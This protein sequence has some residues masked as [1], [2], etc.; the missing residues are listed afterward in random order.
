MPRDSRASTF[1]CAC[2]R[3]APQLDPSPLLRL[4][5]PA[6]FGGTSD[7]AVVSAAQQAPDQQAWIPRPHGHALG[8]GGSVPPPQEGPQAAHRLAAV[9]AR[10]F[11]TPSARLPRAHRL[12][13]ASDIRRCLTHGRRR[14]FEHLDMIWMDNTTGQPRMGLIVPKFQSSAVARNR[15]RRRLREIWRLEIQ[16][17]QPA[18]D[19]VIKARREAYAAAFDALRAQLLALARRRAGCR[20]TPC[21]SSARAAPSAARHAHPRLPALHLAARCRRAAGFTHPAPS[22]HSKRSPGTAPSGAPGWPRVGS[23]A[24]IR[25]IRAGS[26]PSPDLVI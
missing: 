8:T 23:S 17:A 24:V 14:R 9:E 2:S 19:L 10:G 11:L 15:F 1:A 20:V 7:E 18:W 16:R 22:T 21:R 26:T 5:S 6:H 25:S 13:R 4:T 3:P 12:A